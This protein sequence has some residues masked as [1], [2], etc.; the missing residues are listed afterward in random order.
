MNR[1]SELVMELIYSVL[2]ELCILNNLIINVFVSDNGLKYNLLQYHVWIL[3]G[4]F[5]WL[6]S[7]GVESLHI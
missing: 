2:N 3:R 4:S 6:N 1:E 5:Y 7:W